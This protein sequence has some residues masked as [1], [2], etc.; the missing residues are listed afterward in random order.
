MSS[1][2][3]RL[4][5]SISVILSIISYLATPEMKSQTLRILIAWDIGTWTLIIMSWFIIVTS[6]QRMTKLRATGN[7]PGRLFVHVVVLISAAFSLLASIA[8]IREREAR[9][10][11]E[12]LW[13]LVC[14]AGVVGAWVLNHTSWTLRYARMY[15]RLTRSNGQSRVVGGLSFPGDHEP[16]DLDFAYFAFTIGSCFQ[17]SDVTITSRSIRRA[18]LLHAISSFAYNTT[19]VSLMINVIFGLMSG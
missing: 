11:H 9:V 16:D 15:Y 13:W 10:G 18:A 5:L 19:V 7:D 6:T 2:S 3:A 14:L 12:V 8:L 1:K 4:R 17:T